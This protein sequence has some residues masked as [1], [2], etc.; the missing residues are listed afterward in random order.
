MQAVMCPGSCQAAKHCQA[1]LDIPGACFLSSCCQGLS[2][3]QLSSCHLAIA[4]SSC[5]AR[6]QETPFRV[7][8][9]RVAPISL[10]CNLFLLCCNFLVEKLVSNNK[11][12]PSFNFGGDSIAAGSGVQPSL[13]QPGLVQLGLAQPDLAHPYNAPKFKQ[14]GLVQ[15]DF[16]RPTAFFTSPDMSL[17]LVLL[18]ARCARPPTRARS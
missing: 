12:I 13:A 9:L 15:P 2:S 10:S 14:L 3:C 5:H 16:M 11:S 4:L 18:Q 1:C 8:V 7:K 6:A 17:P